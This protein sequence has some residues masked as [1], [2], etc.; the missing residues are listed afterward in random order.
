MPAF[1]CVILLTLQFCGC[2]FI[3]LQTVAAEEDVRVNV[4]PSS[5]ERPH[6]PGDASNTRPGK[7]VRRIVPL[8]WARR[9]SLRNRDVR[10]C[11]LHVYGKEK[12]CVLLRVRH[13][14]QGGCLLRIADS[15]QSGY[16]RRLL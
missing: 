16:R 7:S 4:A 11:S 1:C 9:M 5:A 8:L 12:T 13:T 3:R 2:G 10:H 15:S 6:L 14:D